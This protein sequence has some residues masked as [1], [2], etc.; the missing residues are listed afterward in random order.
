M[1]I[2]EEY[3]K[4]YVKAHTGCDLKINGGAIE[5][6]GVIFYI[7]PK[8]IQDLFLAYDNSKSDYGAPEQTLAKIL[9]H[10][11]FNEKNSRYKA[12]LREGR[13]Q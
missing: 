7:T 10:N 2:D 12:L 8:M 6:D 1:N 9:V 11:Y 3:M 13:Y 4:I 5:I